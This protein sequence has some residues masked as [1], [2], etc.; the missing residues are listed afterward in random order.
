MQRRRLVNLMGLLPLVSMAMA[1]QT[2]LRGRVLDERQQPLAAATVAESIPGGATTV[3]GTTDAAGFFAVTMP[4]LPFDPPKLRELWISA[5]GRGGASWIPVADDLI[6]LEPLVLEKGVT[7]IGRTRALDGRPIAGADVR[8]ATWIGRDQ[9]LAWRLS[10]RATSDAA[11]IFKLT[12]VPPT[13]L[14]LSVQAAGYKIRDLAPVA[15]GTPLELTLQ[16][17]E[18]IRGLVVDQDGR[19]AAAT[20]QVE[21]ENHETPTRL[22][23]NTDGTFTIDCHRDAAWRIRAST[24]TPKPQF[25]H[26]EVRSGGATDLRLQLI[27]VVELPAL[28]I[29]ATG[30]GGAPLPAF[31]AVVCWTGEKTPDEYLWHCLYT[32]GVAATAGVACL[33]PPTVGRSESLGSVLVIAPGRALAFAD[34]QWNEDQPG[35]DVTVATGAAIPC[36]G[37]VVDA[38]GEP[39]A[40]AA[41]WARRDFESNWHLGASAA[42]GSG[43]ATAADGTFTLLDLTAGAWHV[44]AARATAPQPKSRRIEF[45]EAAADA[46]KPLRFVLPA[47]ADTRGRVTAAPRGAQIAFAPPGEQNQPFARRNLPFRAWCDEEGRFAVS[48]LL[49]GNVE[50]TLLIARPPRLGTLHLRLPTARVRGDEELEIDGDRAAPATIQGRVVPE[51]CAAPMERLLVQVRTDP[52]EALGQFAWDIEDGWEHGVTPGGDGTFTLTVAGG[53]HRLRVLDTL[54]GIVLWRQEEAV[55]IEAGVTHPF[56]LTPTLAAIELQLTATAADSGGSA[57]HLL[58]L[59]ESGEESGWEP[60]GVDLRVERT[61]NVL[62]V[63]PGN[64]SLRVVTGALGAPTAPGRAGH[65]AWVLSDRDAVSVEF[66][67]EAGQVTPVRVEVPRRQ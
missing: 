33:P 36:R 8:A 50:P 29:R 61:S 65:D 13:N 39:V 4:P 58:W 28:R 21:W 23:T 57:Y 10:A 60:A 49:V 22:A 56:T 42:R 19:P 43:V 16:P 15:I 47:V 62:Y 6:E 12:G 51:G 46:G 38:A 3:L 66:T 52:P 9:G 26:S 14:R 30:D 59:A 55:A 1:Q 25:A 27:P 24:A 40:G 35:L 20:L 2:V 34:V 18:P 7:L 41:V 5:P 32:N 17:A 31:V 67:A 54:T 37:T 64:A 11:G 53:K 44:H 45:A 48:E 63:P